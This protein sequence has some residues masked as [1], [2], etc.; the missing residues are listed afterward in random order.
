MTIR[1]ESNKHGHHTKK[2]Y[3]GALAISLLVCWYQILGEGAGLEEWLSSLGGV[4]VATCT[5]TKTL[6]N[7]QSGGLSSSDEAFAFDEEEIQVLEDNDCF[8]LKDICVSP[9]LGSH[10][11]YLTNH[12]TTTPSKEEI[13]HQPHFIFEPDFNPNLGLPRQVVVNRS[14]DLNH[15]Q[16]LQLLQRMNC[17]ASAIANH[18]MVTGEFVDMAMEIYVRLVSGLWELWNNLPNK[19]SWW[20]RTPQSPHI[21]LYMHI[22]GPMSTKLLATAQPM[23]AGFSSHPVR[24]ILTLFFGGNDATTTASTTTNRC[25]CFSRLVFCGYYDANVRDRILEKKRRKRK[26]KQQQ[27]ST[28]DSRLNQYN[29]VQPQLHNYSQ[30]GLKRIKAGPQVGRRKG[31][32][33]A[34]PI[35]WDQIRNFTRQ[36]AFDAYPNLAQRIQEYKRDILV[37]ALVTTH[38][39]TSTTTSY[40]QI[41]TM[42]ASGKAKWI[43]EEST[44][45]LQEWTLIGFAQRQTRRRWLNL[46]DILQHCRDAWLVP[47]KIVCVEVDL[48][49]D[50]GHVPEN[51]VMMHAGLDALI[52]VHGSQQVHAVWMPDGAFVLELLPHLMGKWGQWTQTT[53]RR[54]PNGKMINSTKLNHVGYP[55]DASS[56]PDC[57]GALRHLEH[58]NNDTR[59]DNRDIWVEPDIIENFV[60]TFLVLPTPAEEELPSTTPLQQHQHRQSVTSSPFRPC[61]YFDKIAYHEFVLYHVNCLLAGTKER[62]YRHYFRPRNSFRHLN[63]TQ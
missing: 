57:H 63:F 28:E 35:R 34:P 31:E 29:E 60:Q 41:M 49:S 44:T 36:G 40:N 16:S 23:M 50:F 43:Q 37:R 30:N 26:K 45:R 25:R 54:T 11:F 4:V 10:W 46:P 6:P 20:K 51:Q 7:W 27:P 19:P 42:K 55:L 13:H 38:N 48:D 2:R 56:V 17:Q 1:K 47:F 52:G 8:V 61:D 58:C 5:A 21:Q 24:N 39:K 33:V 15:P 22:P 32:D 59:W 53:E 18:I 3:L 12:S 14:L 62:T 9:S